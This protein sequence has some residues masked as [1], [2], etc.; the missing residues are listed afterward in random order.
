[1]WHDIWIL[2]LGTISSRDNE[3]DLVIWCVFCG[4]FNEVDSWG[5]VDFLC[6]LDEIFAS[7]FGGFCWDF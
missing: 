3:A 7:F 1:M 5:C 2:D 6:C 4:F